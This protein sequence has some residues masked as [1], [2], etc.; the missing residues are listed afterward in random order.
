MKATEVL[1]DEH[2]V[3]ERVLGA[4]EIAAGRAERGDPVRPGLF[5]EAADF[6]MNFADGSHHHK[7]EGVL[8]K[9]MI[10]A[11]MPLEGGPIAVMLSEHEQ[12][13]AYT[14]SLREAAERWEQGDDLARK[15]VAQAATS[16]AMLL[17]QHIAKEDRI[18][19]PMADQ[20]I[21]ASKHRQVMTDFANVESDE[22]RAAVYTKYIGL[23]DSLEQEI[24]RDTKEN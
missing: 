9:V 19:F 6:I 23:A 4:L 1:M 17:R 14:R 15:K 12:A 22:E 2:R 10:E 18:L 13:R 11:G 16:Y 3:I 5:L 7:E 20:A 8:F 21:P 24:R